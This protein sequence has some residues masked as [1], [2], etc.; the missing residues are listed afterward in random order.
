MGLQPAHGRPATY[1]QI[2]V[3][4]GVIPGGGGT[5]RLARLLGQSKAIAWSAASR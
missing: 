3:A 5:A 1:A 2:E 4:L